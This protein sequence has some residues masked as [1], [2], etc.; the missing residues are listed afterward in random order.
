MTAPA[1]PPPVPDVP[2]PLVKRH[3]WIVRL[4]HWLTFVVLLG[5]ITSGL[6]IYTAYARFGERGGPYYQ[7]NPFQDHGFPEWS[8]LGHWLAGALNWHFALAWLLVGGG[9]LYVSYLAASGEWRSLLFRPRDVRGAV[10]MQK[11][12]LRIRKD[13]PPQGKHNPLQKLAYSSIVLLGALSVLTGFAIYKPTQLSWLVKLFGGFQAAR[14]WHF[15]A[16]WIF[17]AFLLVHVALVFVV[18]PASLRA[19]LS[20]WYRGRFPSHD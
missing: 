20:G 16:V 12:Y 9:L 14:Y 2:R 10:E 7:P 6:Q 4:T 11:Y 3:H 13:H 8:R 17:T 15:W 19:M 5:M 1:A 18:D